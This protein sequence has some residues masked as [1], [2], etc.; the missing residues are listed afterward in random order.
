MRKIQQEVESPTAGSAEDEDD[1]PAY[2]GFE[3]EYA[4][5]GMVGLAMRLVMLG[6]LCSAVALGVRRYRRKRE[7]G[8]MV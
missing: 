5:D 7:H 8:K 2:D 6:G 3:F 1:E 4:D